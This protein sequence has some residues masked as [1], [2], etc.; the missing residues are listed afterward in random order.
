VE[1]IFELKYYFARGGRMRKDEDV[2]GII[3]DLIFDP[4]PRARKRD[5]LI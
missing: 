4:N 2:C 1:N 5:A 3:L